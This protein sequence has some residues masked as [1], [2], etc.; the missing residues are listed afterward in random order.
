ME[1][2]LNYDRKLF[3]YTK[4]HEPIY[5]TIEKFADQT[6]NND[7]AVAGFQVKPYASKDVQNNPFQLLFPR[8]D[9]T[10]HRQRYDYSASQFISEAGGAA[11]IGLLVLLGFSHSKSSNKNNALKHKDSEAQTAIH[12]P[13]SE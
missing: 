6:G 1:S 8:L 12:I 3:Q 4:Y 10:L 11:V 7:I 2:A 13:V 9:V 5:R